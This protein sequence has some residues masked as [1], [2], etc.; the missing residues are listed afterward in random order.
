[1][2]DAIRIIEDKNHIPPKNIINMDFFTKNPPPLIMDNNPDEEPKKKR[3][4]TRKKKMDDGNEIVLAEQEDLPMY[5]TNAPYINS[6]DETTA[7]LKTSVLQIDTLENDIKEQLDYIKGSK[8]LKK[9]YDYI[10]E[11][12]STMS[13]LVSTKVT[14]IRE[15]NKTITDCHNLEIKRIKDLKIGAPEEQNDDKR[16]MDLYNA[17]ISTPM[18]T[19]NP[20][21]APSINDMTLG[22]PNLVSANIV[23][24]DGMNNNGLNPIQNQMLLMETNQNIK[25]VVMYDQST[26][27]RWFTN[28]DESTGQEMPELQTPDPMFIENLNLDIHNGVARDTNLDKTYPLI[29]LGSSNMTNY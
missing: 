5:Q 26:G 11:L 25:T 8:T 9:K 13:S 16:I 15:I 29:T 24:A 12:A 1:M 23:S 7:M 18:G 28:I 14:A 4:Y 3:K 22:S 19:Y 20:L 27:A 2:E 6:Y 17:F 10:G 21:N